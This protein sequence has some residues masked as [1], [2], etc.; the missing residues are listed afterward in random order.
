MNIVPGGY[1]VCGLNMLNK[2][3]REGNMGFSSS[4]GSNCYFISII[5]CF[6]INELQ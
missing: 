1:H 3:K 2:I 5:I 6:N 4:F